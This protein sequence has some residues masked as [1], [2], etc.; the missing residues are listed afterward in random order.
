MPYF[1]NEGIKIYYEIE[2]KGHDLIMIHGFAS[3]MEDNWKQPGWIKTLKEENRL[4]LVDCRGHG[5]SDK[6]K[7]PS[8]YGNSMSRDIVKLMDHLD[9]KSSNLFGYSMGSRITLSFIINY[10]ERVKCAILGGF[11]PSPMSPERVTQFFEPTIKALK[12][13]SVD[14]IKNPIAKQFRLFAESRGGDL[15]ALAAVMGG[16]HAEVESDFVFET[17]ADLKAELEK[18]KIPILSVIGS[19]D[20]LIN[21]KTLIA[22]LVPDACY[23][24]IQG[25]DHLTVVRD[26]K[27]H[28]V[29]KAFLNYANNL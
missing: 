27:F 21:N 18:I 11:I 2:G 9:I 23:F 5:K 28:M 1:D 12:A 26:P 24:Q 16:S 19:L 17:L 15:D 3:N 14:Q 6:P 20:V 29:V 7:D 13:K 25:K 4:I 8:Q 10:P 22:D